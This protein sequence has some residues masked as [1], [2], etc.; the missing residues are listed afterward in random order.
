MDFDLSLGRQILERTPTTLR[1]LLFDL[2]P[3]WTDPNE[4]PGTWSPHDVLSHLINGERTDW[5]PRARLI[6]SGDRDATFVPFDRE[7]WFAEG[8]RH[9][10][11]E[12]LDIFATLRAANLRALDSFKIG[13]KQ[14][15]MTALHPKFGRVTMRQLLATWVVHDLNHLVQI[16]RVMAKQYRDAVGPWTEFLGVLK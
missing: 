7:G 16:N 14:L 3:E 9:E 12:L 1:A 4:G 2:P 6:L 5:I 10:V 15:T 8:R 11:D 13:E